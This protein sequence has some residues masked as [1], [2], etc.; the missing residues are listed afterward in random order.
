MI[1]ILEIM[2]QYEP[3]GPQENF[4]LKNIPAPHLKTRG[5]RAFTVSA[6]SP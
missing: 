5:G 6:L 4:F 3:L 2:H 1:F